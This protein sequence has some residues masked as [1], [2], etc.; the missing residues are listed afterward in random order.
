MTLK[1]TKETL[2]AL[3]T[4]EASE[5]DAG[6]KTRYNCCNNQS[7]RHYCQSRKCQKNSR[8]CQSRYGKCHGQDH[9]SRQCGGGGHNGGGH[10]GGNHGNNGGDYTRKCW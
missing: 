6:A 1:L 5:V 8:Q 9:N 3:S 4:E 10:G 7:R 2:V